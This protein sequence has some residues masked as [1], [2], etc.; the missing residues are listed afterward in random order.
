MPMSVD[1]ITLEPRS[2]GAQGR[3]DG[4]HGAERHVQDGLEGSHR[5]QHMRQEPPRG[6]VS[7]ISAKLSSPPKPIPVGADSLCGMAPRTAAQRLMHHLFDEADADPMFEEVL[8]WLSASARYRSFVESNRDK[9]RK[10]LRSARDIEA[11]RD[12]RAELGVAR[13]LLEDRRIE[14]AFEAYGSTKGGPDFTLA[15]RDEPRLNLEVTRL[16]RRPAGGHAGP[17]LGKLRQLP[18]SV[19][20]IVLVAVDGASAAAFDV[21]TAAR[22]LRERADARDEAYFSGRGFRGSREF[23]QRYVRLGGVLV[24]AEQA[25]GDHRVSWWSNHSARITLPE[26]SVRAVMACFRASPSGS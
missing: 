11:R 13:A 10:K 17:L 12:V 6:S 23:N 24:W 26:R 18:P 7:R 25:R 8:Q 19:P 1:A 20:N 3:I 21:G 14:L 4:S 9:I 16:R 15:Y 5:G 22:A 2:E